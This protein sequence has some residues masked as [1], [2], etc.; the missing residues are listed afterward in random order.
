[1]IKKPLFIF[2][3]I[4]T[5]TFSGC[6]GGGDSD[7][8]SNVPP[9]YKTFNAASFS[10]SIP[11]EWEIIEPVDFTSEIPAGTQVIFANNVKNDVFTENGNVTKEILKSPV[12]SYDFGLNVMESNKKLK[13]YRE[14]SRDNEYEIL[15]GGELVKTILVE[16]EGKESEGQPTIRVF[17]TY[18]VSGAD[19]Y[20]ISSAYYYGPVDNLSNET[21]E[22]IVKT[23][24]VK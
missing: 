23:F 5:L 4:S 14:I 7:I 18:A 6:F 12:S 10:I 1:M 13:N 19:A 22:Q 20:T 16:F 8:S 17:Q 9:G 15:I 11:S 24:R 21:A 2:A 3:L